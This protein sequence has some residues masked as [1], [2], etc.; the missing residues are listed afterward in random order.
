MHIVRKISVLFALCFLIRGA[1]AQ[2]LINLQ[3]PATGVYLKSQLWNFSIVNPGSQSMTLKVELRF[4]DP[5]NSQQIFTA[6]SRPFVL[7]GQVTQFQAADLSP[8]VYNI[9]NSSYNVDTNPNGFLPVG[10]FD[11]CFAVIKINEYTTDLLTEQCETILVEPLSPPILMMPFDG[12]ETEIVRPLFTWLPPSPVNAFNAL[13][14]NWLLTDVV[15]NQTPADAVQQNLPI[16][17]AQHLPTN[18]LSYPSSLP[19]LDTGK[20]YA[21]RVQAVSGESVVAETEIWTF[22]LKK[23][24]SDSLQNMLSTYSYSPLQR[25]I[26]GSYATSTG[27]L[28]FEYLNEVNDSVNL[29]HVYDISGPGRQ[30]LTAIESLPVLVMGQNFIDLDLRN[31]PGLVDKHL[32]LLEWINSKKESWYLKFEY[33]QAT[34]N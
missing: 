3:L 7:T 28:H 34:S 8:I 1:Q 25:E 5:T 33:R 6:S 32:Y 20:L 17:S 31:H 18:S 27:V 26:S 19:A 11:V 24:G 15:G 29:I 13:S 22:R 12:E 9:I 16:H 14:Y 23:Y 10:Q 4:S 21:W 2:V 30:P